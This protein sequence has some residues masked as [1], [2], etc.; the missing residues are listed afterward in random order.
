MAKKHGFI[1]T[2]T[3]ALVGLLA[4]GVSALPVAM[5]AISE[6]G[7]EL[8]VDSETQH[9][10][11][12]PLLLDGVTYVPLRE[13]A[14]NLGF[15]VEWDEETG[16]IEVD[17]NRRNVQHLETNTEVISEQGVI[18]DEE[19]ALAVG[20]II[21]E[22]A[23]GQSVEYQDGDRELHLHAN[24]YTKL[25]SWMVYQA[26]TYEGES[27]YWTNR[28]TP[29]VALNKSTGEVTCINLDP[30]AED[31]TP[32]GRRPDGSLI[33][34]TKEAEEAYNSAMEEYNR[35]MGEETGAGLL[36]P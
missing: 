5:Q 28:P 1:A 2:G 3:L 15:S 12:E 8:V 29:F 9:L 20:K 6:A 36:S 30:M 34:S 22:K 7:V 25:N 4:L 14:E 19:T 32:L 21:L 17:T 13:C 35:V 33:W 18:P 27:Y 31:S 10:E 11:H 23:L 16:H 26:G 24:Y